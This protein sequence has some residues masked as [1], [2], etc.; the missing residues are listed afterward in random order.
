MV[1]GH[2]STT[3]VGKNNC[4]KRGVRYVRIRETMGFCIFHWGVGQGIIECDFDEKILKHDRMRF[5][6]DLSFLMDCE[7]ASDFL[8]EI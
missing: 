8:D 2:K 4:E 1:H 3:T 7:M 5:P 6:M